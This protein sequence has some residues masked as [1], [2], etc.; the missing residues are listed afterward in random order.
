M[1]KFNMKTRLQW[2]WFKAALLGTAIGILIAPTAGEIIGVSGEKKDNTENYISSMLSSISFGS[3]VKVMI[4]GEVVALAKSKEAGEEAFQSARLAYNAKGVQILDIDV[5]YE[6]VDK[7]KDAEAI[8]GMR[9]LRKEKLTEAVLDS[10]DRYA[11]SDKELAYTMRIDDYTV[12][13]DSMEDLVSVLEKAQGAYDA[14]DVFKVGLKPTA[15]RNVTMYEVDVTKKEGKDSD[16]GKEQGAAQTSDSGSTSTQMPGS[17]AGTQADTEAQTEETGSTTESAGEPETQTEAPSEAGQVF[18]IEKNQKVLLTGAEASTEEVT[19]TEGAGD[20]Q[21]PAEGE[22]AAASTEG[23]NAGEGTPEEGEEGTT[24]QSPEVLPQAADDGIK[25]VGFSETIQ[26]M[27]TY[28]NKEQIKDKDTAYNEMTAKNAEA[29]IYVVERGDCLSIIAEKTNMSVEE[30]KELNPSIESDDN[31]FYD[32]RLNITVPTAAVQVLVEKQ[33]TYQENYNEEV[34]YQDDDSMYIGETEVVQEGTPG[35]HIVTDLV[36]YK[37]DMECDREQLQETVEVAAVAQVVK[38]G[39]KSKPTYMFPVTNWN[40]TS[41]FGYR[42]GRLHA[43]TDVG[44]PTGTTVR[45]S[46][47][48]QIITAGWLGGYGNCVIIDHGDGVCTRYGHLS[49]VTV[50]VGQYVDQGQ[51]V[52]LS[53]NTG[54]STGPHLHFEIRI[55]GEAVDPTPYLYQTQ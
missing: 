16:A 51:Q 29:D 12:T 35:S 4:N 26:V 2:G 27:E 55:N 45:A 34:V 46:R 48:G 52:A 24:A 39:T 50:S 7:E 23:E 53:G 32:D 28:V 30:I 8:E 49:E 17:E 31:L 22:P 33:E 3:K 38:R 11:E 18:P 54:R 41:N 25:Y 20:T 40:V 21:A 5:T 15:S 6:E 9:L 37:D 10:F 36:T 19:S 47:A 13:I 42:W 1:K 43:G 44:V 14:E